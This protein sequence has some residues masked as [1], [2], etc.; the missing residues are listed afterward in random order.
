MR[1]QPFFIGLGAP[2]RAI[3]NHEMAVLDVGYVGE[4]FVIPGEA[5]DID[6]H[7]AQVRHGGRE[8]RVYHG[9][10]VPVEIMRRDVDLVRLGERGD[11]H[12]LPHAV[13]HRVDDRHVDRLLA[14]VRQELA[15]A[16]QGLAR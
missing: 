5:I 11:L 7:D 8:M 4:E 2:T 14:E 1:T 10:E 9:A 16:E 13:P 12:R 6:L 3:R 15:D